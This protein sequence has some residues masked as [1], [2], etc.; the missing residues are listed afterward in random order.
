MPNREQ[1]DSSGSR[2]GEGDE[3]LGVIGTR[4]TG[5]P[6]NFPEGIVSPNSIFCLIGEG[7]AWQNNFPGVKFPLP[8]YPSLPSI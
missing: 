3:L 8:F 4:L 1:E 5:V 2:V 7:L 6:G